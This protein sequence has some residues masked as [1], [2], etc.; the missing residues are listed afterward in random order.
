MRKGRRWARVVTEVCPLGL[1]LEWGAASLVHNI[2]EREFGKLVT[3]MIGKKEWLRKRV[4]EFWPDMPRFL[5]EAARMRP[6][7]GTR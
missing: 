3:F 6:P 2:N 5:L 7:N 1:I 4:E